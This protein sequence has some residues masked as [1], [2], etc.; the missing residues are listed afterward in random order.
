MGFHWDIFNDN[1]NLLDF[2][3]MTE[4]IEAAGAIEEAEEEE[5][6]AA[7]GAETSIRLSILVIIR[8]IGEIETEEIGEIETEV[9]G[10][11]EETEET[12]EIEEI[13]LIEIETLTTET[14][15]TDRLFCPRQ[16][17][18]ILLW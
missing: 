6:E 3:H 16:A 5:V 15:T 13:G 11:T 12:E 2:H 14:K 9:T 8:G 7:G 18:S 4:M 17:V 1:F 10:E